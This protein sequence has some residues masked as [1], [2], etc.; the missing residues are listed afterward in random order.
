MKGLRD[1]AREVRAGS[2][3]DDA[4]WAKRQHDRRFG[5]VLDRP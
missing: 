4:V 5:R 3:A 1:K 2:Q